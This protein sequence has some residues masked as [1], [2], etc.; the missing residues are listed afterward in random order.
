MP[1]L[2]LSC[3]LLSATVVNTFAQGRQQSKFSGRS[4]YFVE[5]KG[6]WDDEVRYLHKG[7]NVNVWITDSAVVYD[8]YKV[9]DLDSSRKE[10]GNYEDPFDYFIPDSV[11]VDG[12]LVSLEFIQDESDRKRSASAKERKTYGRIGAGGRA[13]YFKGT[14][15]ENW[16]VNAKRYT[17]VVDDEIYEGI[18]TRYYFQGGQLR[19]D[20]V[21]QPGANP[22]RIKMR[23]AGA[24]NVEINKSG[25]LEIE[26]SI[27]KIKH[28]DL[29]TFEKD[30]R[31]NKNDF[32]GKPIKSKFKLDKDGYVRFDLDEY[33]TT[34]VLI[35][36]PLIVSTFVGG[37]NDEV[38]TSAITDEL[39]NIYVTGSTQSPS[40][41]INGT[42]G[43]YTNSHTAGVGDEDVF[44]FRLSPVGDDMEWIT[45]FGGNSADRAFDLVKPTGLPA[46]CVVGQA[47]AGFPTAN[48]LQGTHGGNRDGFVLMLSLDGSTLQYSSYVGASQHD[49][50]LSVCANDSN[51]VTVLGESKSNGIGVTPGAYQTT[52]S[53]DYDCFLQEI[54]FSTASTATLNYLTYL[55]GND[56]ERPY[57]IHVSN[58]GVAITGFTESTTN[59]PTTVD[60]VS[61]THFGGRDIFITDFNGSSQSPVYS[62]YIGTPNED[63]ATAIVVSGTQYTICGN[64]QSSNFPVTTGAYQTSWGGTQDA[65]VCKVTT[66]AGINACTYVGGN[67]SDAGTSISFSDD[68][69]ILIVGQTNSTNLTTTG[70]VLQS[71]NDGGMDVMIARLNSDLTS[72]GLLTYLGGNGDDNAQALVIDMFNRIIVVGSTN[73]SNYDTTT[74]AYDTDLN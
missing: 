74:G 19:Y 17:E 64:T 72:A 12:H 66:S 52:R 56:R 30:R 3:I 5:N 44:V 42:P 14:D 48:P 31:E 61:Q 38:C 46:I 26:T 24:N 67:S 32:K 71:S 36:D 45:Y 49:R 15:R 63:V 16:V 59:F 54:L 18:G 73:S 57:D 47:G 13:S 11:R 50:S 35:I 51:T 41:P 4:R 8:Y 29:K 23:F 21:V 68:G 53:G 22:K 62:T 70:D 20:I 25:E 10:L 6:Q 37:V 1:V 28:K 58:S 40:F 33:D 27:G 65:F 39:G 43:P 2:I 69:D 7:K 9:T 55:G 60:A 34:K